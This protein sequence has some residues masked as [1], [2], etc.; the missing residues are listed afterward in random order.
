MSA[1]GLGS[2]VDEA[3]TIFPRFLAVPPARYMPP[4]ATWLPTRTVRVTA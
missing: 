1:P 2:Y 3:R 4:I